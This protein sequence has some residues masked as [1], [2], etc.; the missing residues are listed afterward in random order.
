MRAAHPLTARPVSGVSVSAEIKFDHEPASKPL[1]ATAVTDARGYAAVDFDLPR[2]LNV[3]DGELKV[4]ARRGDFEREAAADLRD[5][6]LQ[7]GRIL[8]STDRPLYQPGQVLHLRALAF[9][10]SQRAIA[11][12]GMKLVISDPEG[13]TLFRAALKTSRFGV[14]N[15]DWPIPESTRLGEYKVSVELED[16]RYGSNESLTFVKISRYDL[17]NFTVSVKPNR[18]Y[19][20]SGQNAEVEVRADY[21]FG[22]PVARGHV[23]VVRET[24]R[25]WNY[26]EQK[27]ETKE[28]EKREGEVDAAGH[29]TARIDLKAAHTEMAE[30]N[31]RRF[32]D[33]HYAA[34]FT[35]ATTGRTEQRGFDLRVTREAI[36]VYLIGEDYRQTENFPLQF[37]SRPPT[38]TAHPRRAKW[39]SAK[40]SPRSLSAG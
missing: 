25:E 15:A 40:A 29:F 23:R 4:T 5:E 32:R 6:H 38:R 36:H 17:P 10:F 13:T 33:L 18:A 16:D 21:L 19:Y 26:R 28:E 37:T 20:L 35:D 3:H 22:Q 14:S 2:T 12:A 11:D 39:R 1:K 7:L 9:D 27:W 31:Y 34:Y 8:L 30:E 24:D